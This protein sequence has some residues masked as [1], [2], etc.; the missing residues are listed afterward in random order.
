MDWSKF[1]YGEHIMYI[2]IMYMAIW[3]GLL[4]FKVMSNKEKINILYLINSLF[5][6]VISSLISPFLL[7]GMIAVVENTN[8]DINKI[9]WI[10]LII[11]LIKK[12]YVKIIYWIRKILVLDKGK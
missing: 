6:V 7:I 9:F 11:F 8:T 2:F 10:I 4:A 5:D 3:V 1:N 12:F